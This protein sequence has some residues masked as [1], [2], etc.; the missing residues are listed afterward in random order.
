MFNFDDDDARTYESEYNVFL[1]EQSYLIPF[2]FKFS[3]LLLLCEYII[4]IIISELE[5]D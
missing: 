5:N 1:V 2:V 3:S 4:I